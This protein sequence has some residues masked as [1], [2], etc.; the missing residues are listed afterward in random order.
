VENRGNNVSDDDN[1]DDDEEPTADWEI[2]YTR[3]QRE[4]VKTLK[5]SAEGQPCGKGERGENEELG[6]NKR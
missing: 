4:N 2:N 3:T 1:D 5:I 6:C